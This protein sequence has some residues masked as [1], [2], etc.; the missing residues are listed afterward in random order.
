V[1][2]GHKAVLAAV[3]KRDPEKAAKAMY[4]HL[5]MAEEDL[6]KILSNSSA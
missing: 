3:R 4:Q 2:S 5:R 6:R 1:I